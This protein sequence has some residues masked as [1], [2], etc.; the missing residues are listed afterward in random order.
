VVS[1]LE[2]VI[3]PIPGDMIVV[4]GG[5]MVGLGAVSFVPVVLL[6]TV[7]G[8]LGFM[9]MF[10]LGW[11]IGKAVLD[12]NRL[13]W[14]PKERAVRVSLWLQKYGYGVV[15]A[16]RFLSGARSVIAIMTGAARMRTER[17]ALFATVS[18]GLW[19]TVL[20][21]LG[22]VVGEQWELIMHGLALYGRWVT[23]VLLVSAGGYV[24]YRI[25]RGRQSG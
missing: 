1:Y 9:T 20:V 2:N 15:L 22:Y 4:L 13:R 6:S 10:A 18:A 14:I 3:P 5:Y 21:V 24:I 11:V 8:G 23:A 17:V 12:P 19:S 16:N 25:I 7:A